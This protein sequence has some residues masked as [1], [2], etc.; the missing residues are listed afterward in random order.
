MG[1]HAS[2]PFLVYHASMY[3]RHFSDIARLDGTLDRLTTAAQALMSLDQTFQ[4]L[5]P[6]QLVGTC[7]TV[8]IRDEELVIYTN[9]G[10]IA[11]RLRM[12]APGLLSRLARQGYIAGKV[13]VKVAIK[14]TRKP[15]EKTLKI[16]QSALDGIE[17]AVSLVSNPL[18]SAALL[19]LI[20]HHRK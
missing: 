16:S 7:R 15:R 20:A 3:G 19:K 9:S 1:G 8:R 5:L 4:A 11:A 17:T 2:S 18:V 6:P 13:R 14:V 10:M 12:L